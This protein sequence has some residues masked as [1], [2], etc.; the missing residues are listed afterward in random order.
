MSRSAVVSDPL[1]ELIEA[2]TP[3]S[4]LKR[5]NH[6]RDHRT[7]AEGIVYRF[8]TGLPG[9]IC[10]PSSAHGRWC[11]SDTA[12]SPRTAYATRYTPRC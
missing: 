5:G 12:G 9:V 1:W 11:G 6:F 8:R 7:I 4:D 10:G 2:F 3:S